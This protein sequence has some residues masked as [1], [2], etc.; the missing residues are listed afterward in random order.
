M[1][2]LGCGGATQQTGGIVPFL[3]LGVHKA[4]SEPKFPDAGMSGVA[5]EAWDGACG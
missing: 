3:L 5:S 4:A 1:H 2:G